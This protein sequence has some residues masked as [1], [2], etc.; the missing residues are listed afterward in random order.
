MYPSE[1]DTPNMKAPKHTKQMG[2]DLKGETESNIVTAEHF[3]TPCSAIDRSP[4]QKINM[5]T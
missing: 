3:K 2:T 1:K 5:E 4:R